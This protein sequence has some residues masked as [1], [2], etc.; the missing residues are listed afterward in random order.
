MRARFRQ[1]LFLVSNQSQKK[2]NL[3]RTSGQ[4]ETLIE[5]FLG[6]FHFIQLKSEFPHF[7]KKQSFFTLRKLTMLHFHSHFF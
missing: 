6:C 2:T 5:Y 7:Q 1:V 4:F 3:N